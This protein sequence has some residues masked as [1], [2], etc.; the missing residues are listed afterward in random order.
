MKQGLISPS[1]YPAAFEQSPHVLK[2]NM[3][4]E[5]GP[6]SIYEINRQDK[7]KLEVYIIF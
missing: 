7:K 5:R 3:E 6:E 1:P 2:G 4:T